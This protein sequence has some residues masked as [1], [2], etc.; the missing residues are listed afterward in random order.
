SRT[1]GRFKRFWLNL[2]APAVIVGSQAMMTTATG[3]QLLVTSLLPADPVITSEPAEPLEGEPANQEPMQFRLRVEAPGGPQ[4]VRFLHVL[5]GADTGARGDEVALVQSASGTP[6]V[7]ALVKGTAVLF[8]MDLGTSFSNLTFTVPA[9]TAGYMVTGLTLNASYEVLT[10]PVSGELQVTVRPGTGSSADGGG[11]LAWG[12]L[13]GD[14]QGQCRPAPARVVSAS[15]PE[16]PPPVTVPTT[17][18]TSLPPAATLPAAVGYITFTVAE[19]GVYRIAAQPGAMPENVSRAL[20]QLAPGAGDEWLNM[21]PDGAWLLLST[22]RFDPECVG[23]P[24]LALVAGDLSAVVVVRAGGQVI[25][26]GGFSALASGGD[27]IVYLDSGGPHA[28]D[29][30]VVTRRGGNWSAPVLLTGNSPYAFNH[31]PA[32]SADGRQVVFDCADEPYGAQG[33]AL[34]EVGTDGT[35][36]RVMLTPAESPP[37]L[38]DSGALH[39]PDYAPDGSIVFE[40]D[41]NGEQIWR[42]APG[43]SVPDRVSVLFNNDNSPCV[44]PDGTIASLWLNRPENVS[45]V[46]EIKVMAADGSSYLLALTD[47]D[48]ADYGIGCGE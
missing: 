36:F 27:L 20:D 25:H 38:P 5:Q 30:W 42:L 39:Q 29:L 4:D 32:L 37:G 6:F 40:A 10:E 21:S 7:G 17:A 24:C 19:S 33:T 34:C 8:P 18:G 16:E 31:Q 12:T 45:G 43:A 28:Q 48:V 2:P 23:W 9:N 3:Q 26:P 1:A 22:D 13:A 46:H 15:A 14:S 41:W 11:V 35:G 47:R 44:L